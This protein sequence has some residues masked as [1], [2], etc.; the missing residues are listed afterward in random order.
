MIIKE[1]WTKIQDGLYAEPHTFVVKGQAITRYNLYSDSEHCF[2]S[3]DD[4]EEFPAYST[5]AYTP[6][7]TI[8]DLNKHFRS[9]LLSERKIPQ[10]E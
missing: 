1:E 3:M 9:I 4:V 7:K 6:F 8:D 2:Y 10:E 5:M